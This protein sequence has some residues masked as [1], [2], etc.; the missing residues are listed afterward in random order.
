MRK[1]GKLQYGGSIRHP[2]KTT[3]QPQKS[4]HSNAC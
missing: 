4:D 2:S 3:Q 1:K